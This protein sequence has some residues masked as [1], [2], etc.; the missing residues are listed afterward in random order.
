MA[1]IEFLF[2]K[3]CPNWKKAL[4]NLNLVLSEEGVNISVRK[5]QV[6]SETEAADWKFPG[7]PTIRING[8]DFEPNFQDPG[9]YALV[10]RT[11]PGGENDG[12]LPSEEA[13]RTAIRNAF[14]L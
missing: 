9:K 6:R 14:P 4:R 11:Y 5:V 7:S 10:C 1:K 2:F 8:K 3:D 12:A 13:L